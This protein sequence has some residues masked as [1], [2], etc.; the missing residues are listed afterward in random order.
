MA[1]PVKGERA[2]LARVQRFEHR[3]EVVRE[4]AVA[5]QQNDGPALAAAQVVQPHAL[6][7]DELARLQLHLSLYPPH[8]HVPLVTH[9][10]LFNDK[11]P[12]TPRAN[13]RNPPAHAAL[14]RSTLLRRLR[15][16]RFSVTES[17]FRASVS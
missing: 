12:R 16:P 3:G 7:L 5:M 2:E 11:L 13:S 9:P 8:R 14:L 4:A 17:R 10:G 1:G 6:D 15:K